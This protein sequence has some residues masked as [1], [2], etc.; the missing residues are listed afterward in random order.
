MC[1]LL[2][3]ML[4]VRGNNAISW[5][6]FLFSF[7][8]FPPLFLE[9]RIYFNMWENALLLLWMRPI[10]P[11]LVTQSKFPD[12]QKSSQRKQLNFLTAVSLSQKMLNAFVSYIKLHRFIFSLAGFTA[13]GP[14]DISG[15]QEPSHKNPLQKTTLPHSTPSCCWADEFLIFLTYPQTKQC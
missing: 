11:I 2:F 15:S 5:H 10:L 9:I 7:F 4:F 1:K 13:Q 8:F 6:D 14:S 3:H 12:K